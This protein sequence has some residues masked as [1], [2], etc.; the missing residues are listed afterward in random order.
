MAEA[1]IGGVM[2]NLVYQNCRGRHHPP[3]PVRPGRTPPGLQVAQI[4]DSQ[5]Y[6]IVQSFFLHVCG[7]DRVVYLFTAT[8]RTLSGMQH[9]STS[10]LSR[11]SYACDV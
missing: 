9:R 4:T 8:G 11:R 10:A 1:M 2:L 7:S 3:Q 6:Y 5:L